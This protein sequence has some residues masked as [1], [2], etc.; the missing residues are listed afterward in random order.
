LLETI[1]DAYEQIAVERE[2]IGDAPRPI[3]R[4]PR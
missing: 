4:K 1:A 3:A 2:G